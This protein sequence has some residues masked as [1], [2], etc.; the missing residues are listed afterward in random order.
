MFTY[1]HQIEILLKSTKINSLEPINPKTAPTEP[2]KLTVD[3]TKLTNQANG[4]SNTSPKSDP[5]TLTN[6]TSHQI[7][8]IYPKRCSI[9][10]NNPT[11]PN[12]PIIN[13]TT[14]NRANNIPLGVIVNEAIILIVKSSS[15]LSTVAI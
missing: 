12:N 11:S 2:S 4:L 1:V 7:V 10:P 14:I 3:P 8:P 15:D 6:P 5:R 9:S 13:P